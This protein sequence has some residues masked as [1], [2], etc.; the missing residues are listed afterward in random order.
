MADGRDHLDVD[1]LGGE[2]LEHRG[3]H[4]R[5]RLHAC[6]DEADARDAAVAR[7]P[8]GADLRTPALAVTPGSAARSS[9]GTVKEMSVTPWSRH[10]L[11]DHVDV[12]VGVGQRRNRRAAMPGRSGTP[13]TVT[14]A[15]DVSCT[16]AET[17]ACSMDGSSSCTQVP[18]SQVNADRTCSGTPRCGRTRPTAWP[19]SGSRTRSS[20]AS[21]RSSPWPC[22]GRRAPAA[23]RR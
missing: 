16:T 12:D 21:R 17:M 7:H 3:R 13:D 14:L 8:A 11:H 18:G 6:A 20:R 4:A 1:A 9:C 2:G 19:A 15:S 22:G 5:V 23:G 10:V